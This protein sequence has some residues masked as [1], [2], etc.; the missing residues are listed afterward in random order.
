MTLE[1]RNIMIP[2]DGAH[3]ELVLVVET[4]GAHGAPRR[5]RADAAARHYVGITQ[6]GLAVGRE[7]GGVVGEAARHVVALVQLVDVVGAVARGVGAVADQDAA[8]LS[9]LDGAG[10]GQC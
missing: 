3:V 6:E 8:D 7:R 9:L 4:D 2:P 5:A 10:E 1:T